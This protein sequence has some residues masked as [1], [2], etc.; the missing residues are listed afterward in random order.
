MSKYSALRDRIED[1]IASL[2]K[3]FLPIGRHVVEKTAGDVAEAALAG[4]IHGSDD[5]VAVA[6]KSLQD[7]LPEI[8]TTVA[9][10]VAAAIVDHEA[11]N[12]APAETS[13]K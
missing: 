6:K 8:K 5:M 2:F 11:E 12:A 7:Q 3:F 1:S 13:E 9:H 10:A 4:T